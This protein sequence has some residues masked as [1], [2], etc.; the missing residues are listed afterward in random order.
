MS[1]LFTLAYPANMRSVLRLSSSP[2]DTG[3]TNRSQYLDCGSAYLSKKAPDI[4]S[5]AK[6]QKAILRVGLIQMATANSG[7]E[8]N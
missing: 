5:S 1:T 6:T 7:V 2:F 3:V 4:H 8:L